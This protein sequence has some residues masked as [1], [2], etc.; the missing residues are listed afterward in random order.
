M[1]NPSL[2]DLD[3]SSEELKKIA[4]LLVQK[5][6]IKECLLRVIKECLKIDC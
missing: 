6:G 4:K 5:R 3:P 2:K 1:L